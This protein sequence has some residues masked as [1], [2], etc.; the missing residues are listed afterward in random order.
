[1]PP[2]KSPATPQRHGCRHLVNALAL[3]L[4]LALLG[5]CAF[6]MWGAFQAARRSDS[7]LS[8]PP[9]NRAAG[10][11]PGRSDAPLPH[12]SPFTKALQLVN[13]GLFLDRQPPTR[14]AS[15]PPDA[16]FP[17]IAARLA[18]PDHAG[19]SPV[20]PLNGGKAP[21]EKQDK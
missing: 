18:S 14:Q 8:Y 5:S 12:P 19:I 1:M 17:P 6:F 9:G 4:L 16:Q 7:A 13:E 15:A 20:K 21:N 10:Q 11:M 3:F 2:Q